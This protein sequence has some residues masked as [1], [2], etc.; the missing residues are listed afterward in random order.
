MKI[1]VLT[2]TYAEFDRILSKYFPVLYRENRGI[3]INVHDFKMVNKF[4][5][6]QRGSPYLDFGCNDYQMVLSKL[7]ERE[8]VELDIVGM[9]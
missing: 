4:M 9:N 7:K 1:V 8:M 6:L 3:F 5:S 2:Q